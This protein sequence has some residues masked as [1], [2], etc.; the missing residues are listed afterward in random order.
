MNSNSVW[1]SKIDLPLKSTIHYEWRIS[2]VNAQLQYQISKARFMIS[3]Q[4]GYSII[5]INKYFAGNFN[6]PI[7]FSI[8][9][10]ALLIIIVAVAIFSKCIF[11]SEKH[12]LRGSIKV[13]Q[14]VYVCERKIADGVFA[15]EN[16][17]NTVR[18]VTNLMIQ[19]K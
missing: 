8:S 14:S 17:M 6:M 11:F 12:H 15:A 4:Q 16:K 2:L 10:Q 9:F 19:I 18:A 13:A 5:S 1:I 3:V 7:A